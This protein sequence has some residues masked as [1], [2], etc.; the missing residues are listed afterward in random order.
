MPIPVSV[1]ELWTEYAA[2]VGGL[3]E[4]RFYEAFAFG[5]SDELAAEL[6]ELV[7]CGTKKAT[8]GS[9]WTFESMGKPLPSPG[10]LSVVTTWSGEPLCIIETLSIDVVPFRS[11]SAEFAA[12]EGEGDGSLEF[13]R[14]AHR[15]YFTRECARL[16]RA[17]SDDMPVSCERFRVVY[18]PVP[19]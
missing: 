1:T 7:L 11:V 3:D 18:Q 17:F 6:A 10:D 16:N 2:T 15:E 5:D 8:A 12:E 9:L 19:R 14:Q 4:S 13:W